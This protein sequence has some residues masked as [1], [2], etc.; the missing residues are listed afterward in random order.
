MLLRLN[1]NYPLTFQL[2]P[3][4]QALFKPARR[5][6]LPRGNGHWT[7]CSPDT[8]VILPVLHGPLEEALTGLA[9]KDPVMKPGDLIPTNRTRTVDQLLPGDPRSGR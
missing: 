9:G 4:L 6:L 2:H 8:H 5:T 7:S 1:S 3:S